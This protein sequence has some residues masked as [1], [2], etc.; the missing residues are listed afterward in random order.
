MQDSSSCIGDLKLMG[1][2]LPFKTPYKGALMLAAFDI[3]VRVSICQKPPETMEIPND[4]LRN[5]NNMI[6][7]K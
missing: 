4:D 3:L 5:V 1:F 2:D 7:K 6:T